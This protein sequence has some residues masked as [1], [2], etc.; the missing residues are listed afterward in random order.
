MADEGSCGTGPA[1][2]RPAGA[3]DR[4][5]GAG[6]RMAGAGDRM[7]GAADRMDGAGEPGRTRPSSG[8]CPHLP[9]TADRRVGGLGRRRG[10][11][12]GRAWAASG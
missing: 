10:P 1:A 9:P 6:D 7:A 8:Q 2:A 12:P 3:A 5:A 4:M 11:G